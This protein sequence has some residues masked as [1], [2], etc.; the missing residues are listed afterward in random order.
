MDVLLQTNLDEAI[1]NDVGFMTPLDNVRLRRLKLLC[2][3]YFKY[4]NA[5]IYPSAA[6]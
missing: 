2:E 4:E 1:A 3:C 5:S 6:T